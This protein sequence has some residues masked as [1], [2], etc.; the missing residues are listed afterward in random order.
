MTRQVAHIGRELSLGVTCGLVAQGIAGSS[1]P[2]E[3]IPEDE[4]GP[5]TDEPSR[6]YLL[7]GAV[8]RRCCGV[9]ETRA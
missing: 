2:Q 1:P 3:P 7:I 8:T 5:A 6:T 4:R 9:A